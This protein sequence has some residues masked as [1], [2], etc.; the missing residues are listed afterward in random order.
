MKS[1]QNIARFLNV[2]DSMDKKAMIEGE[3]RIPGL[4]MSH[5]GFGKTSTI[6]KWCVAMDYNLFTLIP[7][8]NASDD[9]LGL[10]CKEGKDMVRL[11]PPWY[12]KLLKTMENGKRT[13]IFVDE[14][15][16][17]DPYIQGPM[18]NLIFNR[19][20]GEEELPNNAFIVAAGNYS[21]DLMNAFKMSSALVNR[22][23]ILNLWNSDFNVAELLSD[24]FTKAKT[25]EHIEEYFR[26]KNETPVYD[27][28]KFKEWVANSR[29]VSFGK[30]EYTEDSEYGLIGFNSPRA[31]S[32]S[33]RFAEEYM[34]MYSDNLWMR[35]VG[36]TLGK[37]TK[38]EGKLLRLVFE[39]NKD[40]FKKKSTVENEKTIGDICDEMKVVGVTKE[41]L[42]ELHE[43]VRRLPT[44]GGIS[45]V[46]LKKMSSIVT[47][48]YKNTELININNYL[49]KRIEGSLS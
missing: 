19:T 18:L 4:I 20:L 10:N 34:S 14:I 6:K 49:I 15:S 17:C 37:S 31:L 21:E 33:M 43:A 1:N 28:E 16:T 39:A 8:Q 5:P 42:D 32:F 48:N 47:K 44:D 41:L 23:M 3:D 7:S 30:S 12:N 36:D 40:L 25:K 24:S 13:V 26:I 35:V 38:R 45:S 9:I 22:F 46:D 27:Y 2:L 29:E 11:T